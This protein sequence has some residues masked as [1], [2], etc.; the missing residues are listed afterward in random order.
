MTDAVHDTVSGD[1]GLQIEEPLIFEQDSPGAL[2]VDWPAVEARADRLGGLAR[3]GAIGLAGCGVQL[4]EG[5]DHSLAFEP[6]TP[7][8]TEI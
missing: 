1:R 8:E 6:Y 3:E 7:G 4:S 5:I 2:G